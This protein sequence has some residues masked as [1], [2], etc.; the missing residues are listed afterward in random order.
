MGKEAIVVND[1][2]PGYTVAHAVRMDVPA[3]VDV[4]DSVPVAIPFAQVRGHAVD[5]SSMVVGAGAKNDRW[6]RDFV[7]R[8]PSILSAVHGA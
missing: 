2:L 1:D 3:S 5:A 7:G 8:W 6:A 4:P